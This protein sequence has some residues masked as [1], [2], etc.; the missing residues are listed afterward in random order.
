MG[1]LIAALFALVVFAFIT[2]IT[3]CNYLENRLITLELKVSGLNNRLCVV[4]QE[5][6]E[7]KAKEGQSAGNVGPGNRRHDGK[8]RHGKK[9]VRRSTPGR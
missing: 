3:D 7:S 1:F 5:L 8:K 2:Q 9:K 6:E 4:E